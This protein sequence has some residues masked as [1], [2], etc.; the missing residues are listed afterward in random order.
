MISVMS[1]IFSSA[2]HLWSIFTIIEGLSDVFSVRESYAITDWSTFFEG[3]SSSG[4]GMSLSKVTKQGKLESNETAELFFFLV[5][6]MKWWSETFPHLDSSILRQDLCPMLI[7]IM[8][9]FSREEMCCALVEYQTVVL[10]CQDALVPT[11][12]RSSLPTVP[13]AVRSFRQE[14]IC[15]QKLLVPFDVG[16]LTGLCPDVLLEISKY[17]YLD[18]T[19][20]AFSMGIL[21]LLRDRHSKVHLKD[22]PK[23]FLQMIPQHLAPRQVASLLITDD[24]RTPTGHLS[25]LRVFDRLTS[26]TILSE[27]AECPRFPP[28]TRTSTYREW[29]DYSEDDSG[30]DLFRYLR[31]LDSLP[32][33][34]LRVRCAGECSNHFGIDNQPQVLRRKSTIVSFVF[35]VKYRPLHW[36]TH[37]CFISSTDFMDSAVRFIEALVNVQ[38]VRLIIDRFDL[39]AIVC[40]PRWQQVFSRC[41][42]LRR[43]IVELKGRG[44]FQQ[45]ATES[46]QKFRQFRPG[47]IFRIETP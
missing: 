36:S 9:C 11:N 34:H 33:T 3:N 19:I 46:E 10:R 25:L 41:V 12:A 24:P 43:V 29:L 1:F 16:Q 17:L 21:P 7:G 15:H 20:N 35:D 22:P 23:R 37:Q 14:F 13:E 31:D 5:R 40:T 27:R 47:L 45:F 6:L 4:R 44:D 42:H 18:E 39:L 26:L 28:P 8:E 30:R 2:D 32:I 38:Q